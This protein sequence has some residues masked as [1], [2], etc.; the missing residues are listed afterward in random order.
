[1][2]PLGEVLRKVD[3]WIPVVADQ[4][5]REVTVRLWGKGVTL[6]R[7][8]LGAEIKSDRRLRVKSGQFIASRIDARNGAFG[9]IP[10]ELDGAVVTNDFPVFEPDK[11]KLHVPFLGWMSKT[12]TFV[13]LCKAASEGTTNRVRLKEDQFLRTA[14]AL[15]PLAEQRRIV[16]RI[17]ELAAKIAEARH[18]SATIASLCERLLNSLFTQLSTTAP[19]RRLGDI[20]PLIRRPAAIDLSQRY[21]QVS[22]RSFG[23]GT[24]HSGILEGNDITW[25]K[26]HLVKAGDVLISNIKAWEGAIAV[27]TAGDDGRYGS[28]R[29]LTYVPAEGVAT[30][31]WVCHY[32]LSSEGLALVG[33]ASP[34][35]ADRNR[36]TSARALLEITLPVPSITAQ[37]RFDEIYGRIDVVRDLQEQSA[38][39]LDSAMLSLLDRAFK[40][41]LLAAQTGSTS[42][43]L[44]PDPGWMEDIRR[45]RATVAGYVVHVLRDDPELGRT[46]LE[47]ANHF[48]EYH[49]GVDLDRHPV[50]DLFGPNDYPALTEA[51]EVAMSEAWFRAELRPDHTRAAYQYIPGDRIQ[52]AAEAAREL[53]G[54][55]LESVNRVLALIRPLTTRRSEIVATVY[56]AWN[57]L[58]LRGIQPTDPDVIKEIRDNWPERKQNFQRRDWFW[59][60]RWLQA[61]ELTPTGAGRL[62]LHRS[63]PV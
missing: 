9:L 2:V 36:T 10:D 46:K 59:G 25:E 31:R 42:V 11:S 49:C 21:P 57:D 14:I 33:D 18:T 41:E 4:T 40:G 61:N 7:E 39:T 24:F 16:A 35:S 15:P 6:R 30:A 1:M 60:I 48:I 19:K 32:L 51:I 55:K 34:G 47:K 28:H 56:A 58:L 3:D 54:E 52:E 37:R 44:K 27:A 43:D 63:K 5:Y 13:D 8:V 22:V 53:F 45:R 50:G 62:L 29:Y 12:A 38:K 26:P 20:A 17:E 23:R